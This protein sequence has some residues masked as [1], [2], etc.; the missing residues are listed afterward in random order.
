MSGALMS[1]TWVVGV[2]VEATRVVP[3][4]KCARRGYGSQQPEGSAI[5][6]RP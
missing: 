1:E 3:T 5:I 4:A 2:P 6:P